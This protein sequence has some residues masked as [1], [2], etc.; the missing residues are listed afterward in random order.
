M[1]ILTGVLA[2]FVSLP[3]W[4]YLLWKILH[5][6][7]ATELMWFLFWIYVPVGLAVAILAKAFDDTAK[8]VTK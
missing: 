6:V 7:V 5:M 3:I 1:K 4:Y 8:G 2:T